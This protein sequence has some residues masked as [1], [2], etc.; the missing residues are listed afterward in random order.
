MKAILRSGA[1]AAGGQARRAR[2]CKAGSVQLPPVQLLLCRCSRQGCSI[3]WTSF[4]PGVLLFLL[5]MAGDMLSRG[6][7]S[8]AH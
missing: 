4:E 3:S 2:K 8:V 7:L 1:E 6:R 5:N